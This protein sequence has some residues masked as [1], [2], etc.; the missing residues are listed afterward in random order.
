MPNFPEHLRKLFKE[1]GHTDIRSYAFL[2][3]IVNQVQPK[4]VLELGTG[5]GTSAIVSALAMDEGMVYSIDNHMD[6]AGCLGIPLENIQ[7]CG[8]EDKVHLIVGSSFEV[9]KIFESIESPVELIFMDA[10]HN[11]IGLMK[12][13]KSFSKILPKQ[14]VIIIDDLFAQDTLDFLRWLVKYNSYFAVSL[15]NFH[16]G[17]AVLVTSDLYNRRVMFALGEVYHEYS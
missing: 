1:I 9:D 15:V 10:S 17:M 12:E 8:V 6:N 7:A 3:H 11:Y 13:Y 4:N 5:H 14:H 16:D 2:Y